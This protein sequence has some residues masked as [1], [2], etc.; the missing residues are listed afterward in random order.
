M[1]EP[2]TASAAVEK[3]VPW[4]HYL[5]RGLGL[6]VAGV[7]VGGLAYVWLLAAVVATD[8]AADRGLVIEHV[9]GRGTIEAER[10]S[11]LGF[12]LVGRISEVLV[13]EGDHVL[14]GQALARLELAQLTAELEAA[15]SSVDAARSS[16]RRLDAEERAARDALSAAERDE[17]RARELLVRG[18]TAS[19]EVDAAQDRTRAAHSALDRVLAQRTEAT[20]GI[21][22][23]RGGAAARET[24]V[25]RATLLSPFDALVVRRLREPGDTVGIGSTVLRLVDPSTLIARAFVDE[26]TLLSLR[27]G[28]PV[29]VR[30]PD[31]PRTYAGRL[32]HIG[33]E[34][35]R[36]THELPVD[37]VLDPPLDRRV[38]IGQRADVWIEVARTE[39]AVRVPVALIREDRDGTFVWIDRAGLVARAGIELGRIGDDYVEVT[40]GL[41]AGDRVLSPSEPRGTLPVGRRWRRP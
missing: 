13:D 1:V 38:A 39:D 35:D 14:L 10:G 4:R 32:E 30:F 3:R 7:A 23:A 19:A 5:K 18:V 16:L 22:V 2:I 11:Q 9:H 28:Q 31:D 25:G 34:A 12:D 40:G 20:R 36:Q 27:E 37:V 29:E 26:S 6:L 17:R 8:R 15:S 41:D 33:W 24:T 21:E